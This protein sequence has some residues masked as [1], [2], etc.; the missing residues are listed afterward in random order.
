MG[1]ILLAAAA[2]IHR[3]IEP[4]VRLPDPVLSTSLQRS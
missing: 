2:L 3:A 1:L 4:D